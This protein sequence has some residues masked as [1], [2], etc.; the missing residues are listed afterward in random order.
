LRD[1]KKNANGFVFPPS[2]GKQTF[3]PHLLEKR[4]KLKEKTYELKTVGGV[5]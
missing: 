2:A 3:V 4:Y 5:K 1:R